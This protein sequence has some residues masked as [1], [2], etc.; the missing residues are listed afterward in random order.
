MPPSVMKSVPQAAKSPL[1][2][3]LLTLAL[4]LLGACAPISAVPDQVA[5]KAEHL[6][7]FVDL[8]WEA[9]TGRL[10][11]G[12]ERFDTP[13]LYQSSLARG[14]GS[15]DLGFDRGQLGNRQVVRFVR[16]GPRV[17]L[18]ADNLDY[19]ATSDNAEERRAVRESFARSVLW[20]FDVVEE[21][22]GHVLIDGTPFFARDAHGLAAQL[23]AA[24]EGSYS[25]DASR[26]MIYRP[27]TKAF[28]DNT[29]V[30]AVVT[31]TGQP[32]GRHLQTVVP[33][34]QALTVH[35]HHS[36]IRLPDDDYEPLPFEPR[37]GMVSLSW[38]GRGFADYA[39][40]IGEPLQKNYGIRHRLEK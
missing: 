12:V 19:R 21:R 40:P 28:P 6:D 25:L 2:T 35:V 26:S 3:V 27:R 4:F 16:S 23:D 8:Y 1:L 14:V 33:D 22:D 30:E 9:S 34:P 15:N 10:L 17:L 11:I 24:G 38:S 18:M 20:G 36:F 31:L 13:L 29:E 37:S 7:G 5:A 32:E 39:T